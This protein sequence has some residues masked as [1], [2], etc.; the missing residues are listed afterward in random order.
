MVKEPITVCILGATFN[1]PN[2][3]VSVLAAGAIRCVLHSY[4]NARIIQL[5]YAQEGHSFQFVHHDRSIP[6]RFVNLRFSKKFYLRNNIAFLMAL[7]LAS[8]LIPFPKLRRR[9]LAKNG[10]L[11]EIL[12]TDLVVSLA[13]G[14]SFSDIYGI[15]RLLY[16][17]LPQLLALSMGKRLILLPQTIGPF[18]YRFSQAIARFILSKAEIVFSRDA[19]GQ[20]VTRALLRSRMRDDE[21]RFCYD[22]GFDVDPVLPAS[23]I[24][25]GLA[26]ERIIPS[27]VIGLNVSGLLMMGGYAQNNMFGLK[28]PYEKLVTGLIEFLIEERS[29]TVLLIPHVLGSHGESDSGACERVF[30]ALKSKYEGKLGVLRGEYDYAETKYVIGR[31]DFFIGARMHACIGALSQSVPAISIAYSD[32]FI[33]VMKSIGAQDLV[34]DPRGMDQNAMI[35]MVDTIYQRRA[36]VRAQL[37][38]KMPL[39]KKTI[40]GALRDANTPFSMKCISALSD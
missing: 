15:R 20:N 25:A 28:V 31:C 11:K 22:L 9:I 27:G 23:L 37:E 21:V 24:V 29:A 10:Y 1:T 16:T 13:G 39:V 6:V 3:G 7:A 40:R 19:N 26:S 18:R 34:I 2:L 32:K 4:P 33:G 5:D 17:S 8:K 14:D 38:Q 12:Q 35:Q 30:E 36:T